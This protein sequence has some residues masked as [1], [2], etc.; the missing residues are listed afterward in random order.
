MFGQTGSFLRGRHFQHPVQ[1]EVEPT[2]DWIATVNF[3]EP[4]DAKPT[5]PRVLERIGVLALKDFDVHRILA[6]AH[7]VIDFRLRAGQGGVL[8]D[9]R[10]E[11]MRVRA[12]VPIPQVPY[13][14]GM[15][16]HVD[17]NRPDVVAV[18][19]RGLDGGAQGDAQIRVHIQVRLPTGTFLQLFPHE[20][21]SRGAPGEH[22]AVNFVGEQAGIRQ[23]TLHRPQ[24]TFD[25]R[26]NHRFIIVS[27]QFEAQIQRRP[28]LLD[29]EF[30]IDGDIRL[31][32]EPDLGL[33]DGPQQT[34]MSAHVVS[35]VDVVFGPETVGH[36]IDEASVEVVAAEVGVAVAGQDFDD[37]VL[38]PDDADVERT[39]AQ[40]V[41][42]KFPV[43]GVVGLV[44]EGSGRRLMDDAN[45]LQPGEL[46]GL[47]RRLALGVVE[48]GGDGDDRPP[49]RT[50]EAPFGSGLELAQDHRGDLLRR[51][52]L[53]AQGQLDGLA[54]A[55]FDGADG[56]IGGEK[57]L[58][59]GGFT[60]ERRAGL[61]EAD[62]RREHG[63]PVL[64]DDARAA[65]LHDGDLGIGRTQID[66]DDRF[67][68]HAILL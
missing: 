23:G 62:D 35:K 32:G 16:R 18:D 57:P 28:I 39:A 31:G 34:G 11:A 61:G 9:D 48:I 47:A 67:A 45:H 5:D 19:H 59:A 33:F 36:M 65:V 40:V 1:I 29:D 26:T 42:Q 6:V 56:A 13:P 15:R 49:D 30:L 44:D 27:R 38:D 21:R 53:I 55:P 37:A 52:R 12:P 22:D 8:V 43:G 20:G 3:A 2:K 58:V 68:F 7:R 63:L 64:L 25:Q 66:A 17:Q 51:E 41:H 60:D 10:A 50:P 4:L 14:E 46:A 24:G 54:H